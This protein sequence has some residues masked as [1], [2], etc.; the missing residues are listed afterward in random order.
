MELNA[1]PA[2]EMRDETGSGRFHGHAAGI[3]L[4]SAFLRLRFHTSSSVAHMLYHVHTE[5][6]TSRMHALKY[7]RACRL[8]LQNQNCWEKIK[9]SW[10]ILKQ[11]SGIL[12]QLRAPDTQ[13][14]GVIIN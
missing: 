3:G 2:E 12:L 8:C 6:R 9:D 13:N 11:R 1:K 10:L 5:A 7:A 14:F 4:E